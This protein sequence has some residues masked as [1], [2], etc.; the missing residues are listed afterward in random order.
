MNSSSQRRCAGPAKSILWPFAFLLLALLAGCSTQNTYDRVPTTGRFSGEPRM[1][2]LAPN[3]FFFSQPEHGEKF[4]F[5]THK[6]GD[7]HLEVKAGRG[8][9]RWPEFRIEPEEMI[10]NGASIPRN[11]WYVPGFAPFDFTRAAVIHDWLFEAHHRYI[12]A[13][14]TFEAAKAHHDEGAM[15]RSSDDIKAYKRY[16]DLSQEDAADIF[17][18]CIRVA[19]AQ[20]EEIHDALQHYP[21][22]PADPDHPSPEA[23][24]ELQSALRYNRPNSRTLWAYHYFVSPDAFIKTSKKLWEEK[25]CTIETYR[26]LTSSVVRAVALQKGYVSPWLMKKFAGILKREEDRHKDFQRSRP[27][28]APPQSPPTQ[29]AQT[30]IPVVQTAPTQT[31]TTRSAP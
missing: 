27:Q 13:N 4:S 15:K 26:F 6:R 5:T 23:F 19:M 10:T 11:L 3:T 31:D 16:G 21:V 20:S 30:T 7:R 29:T 14:A 12:M 28:I 8:K 22:R 1:V 9:Y 25:H 2:A 17:A 24:R 18:E